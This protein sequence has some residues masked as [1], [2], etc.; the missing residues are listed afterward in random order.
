MKI[1]H[2]KCL[3]LN[4]DYTPM[5][6]IDWKRAQKWYAKYFETPLGIEF[7][8]F[9]KDDFITRSGNRY[10][11]IPAIAKTLSYFAMK[12]GE[13]KFSRKNLFTRDDFTCQY[14]GAKFDDF[15]K[16][17]YDHVIP[18]SK[19]D[20]NTSPTTWTNIVTACY[21][22]NSKKDSMTLKEAGMKLRN[23]PKKPSGGKKYLAIYEFLDNMTNIPEE[24]KPYV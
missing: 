1:G 21:P 9:Y 3:V 15:K 12:H 20:K 24:W 19:W 13:V 18:R 23:L 14:C 11:P 5:R 4:S 16:L 2:S 22:C 17:T 6:I 8:D 7:I 10:E